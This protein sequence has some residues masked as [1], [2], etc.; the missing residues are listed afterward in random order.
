MRLAGVLGRDDNPEL[1]VTAKA[2]KSYVAAV[3]GQ[4]SFLENLIGALRFEYQDDGRGY[5]RRYIP[6]LGYTPLQNVKVAAEYKHEIATS[7]K[8]LPGNTAQD[9]I[10]RIGTLGVTFSF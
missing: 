5:V 4:Y 9:F 10:N 7:Y 6:T 1:T 2:V 8:D 3:E